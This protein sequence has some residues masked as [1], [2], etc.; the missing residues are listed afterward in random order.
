MQLQIFISDVEVEVFMDGHYYSGKA[1]VQ[2]AF[3]ATFAKSEVFSLGV[4]LI[5]QTIKAT[6]NDYNEE[7]D[8]ESTFEYEIEVKSSNLSQVKYK[9]E[10][11][12]FS[13]GVNLQELKIDDNKQTIVAFSK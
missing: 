7:T 8:E 10:I 2:W 3:E 13:S 1:S 9:Y 6:L 11:E 4:S 12:D 5:D